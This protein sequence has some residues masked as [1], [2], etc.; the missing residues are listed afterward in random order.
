M[1]NNPSER[2]RVC[3]IIPTLVQGGAE[4]QMSL[5]AMHLPPERFDSHVIV[6]T[7]S[8]P[9]EEQLNAAGIPVHLIG[10]RG[11]LDP[12]AYWR[13][14]RKLRELAP[15]VVHTWLFAAN[16]YGRFAARRA[17]V[18]VIIAGERCVDPWKSTL[19]LWIDRRMQSFTTAI[20]TNSEAVAR[21]YQRKGIAPHLFRMIPNAVLPPSVPAIDRQ[22][23]CQRL[24]L[25]PRGKIIGAVGRLWKQKG[26]EELIW[27]AELLRIVYNDMWV[28]IVGDGP[29]LQRLQ[30]LRDQYGAGDAI[31]FVGHR[32]DA[33]QLMSA[34]DILWNGSRYEGQSNTILEAMSWGVPVVA[35]DIPGNRDLVIPE[36][37][38]ILYPLGDSGELTRRTNALLRDT[39]LMKRLGANARTRIEQHFSLGRMVDAHAEL[40]QQLLNNQSP[41]QQRSTS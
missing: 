8:G 12:T 10:K 11:K 25:P 32:K 18:P 20:A 4:K 27:S 15:D 28:V 41:P 26:Y 33:A 9:L 36:E 34:F 23:L 3:Q 14:V 19:Q 40:Y 24:Q 39:A 37:T 13:L 38:G 1:E 21:F 31:K 22:E 2:I 5:L 35:S 17:G 29:E 30:R 6:L 16:S 7:H